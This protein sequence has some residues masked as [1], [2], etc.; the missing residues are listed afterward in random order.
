MFWKDHTFCPNM[1]IENG[2]WGVGS[3]CSALWTIFDFSASWG[4]GSVQSCRKFAISQRNL[5]DLHDW[6]IGSNF[7]SALHPLHPIIVFQHFILMDYV[8][9]KWKW[10]CWDKKS[11][12]CSI[13]FKKQQCD[14]LKIPKFIY[15]YMLTIICTVSLGRIS[16][17]MWTRIDWNGVENWMTLIH[18]G[19]FI[20]FTRQDKFHPVFWKTI[21]CKKKSQILKHSTDVALY[22]FTNLSRNWRW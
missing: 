20:L 10:E 3:S 4:I 8:F 11:P 19:N 15:I 9:R 6:N 13:E 16:A 22:V 5:H 1:E 12:F 21:K 18:N 2:G 7:L 14:I 17:I